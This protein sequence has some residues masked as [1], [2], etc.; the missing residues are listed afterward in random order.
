M[1]GPNEE[2][3]IEETNIRA[4]LDA[5][6]ARAIEQ[7]S[8]AGDAV[9]VII[10]PGDKTHVGYAAREGGATLAAGNVER[11]VAGLMVAAQTL[12]GK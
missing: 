3:V 10:G 5:L 11:V 12:S 4:A 9:V 7:N 8:E 1:T 6:A 2:K